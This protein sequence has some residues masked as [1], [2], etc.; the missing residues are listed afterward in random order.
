MARSKIELPV[1][2]SGSRVLNQNDRKE[3]KKS[4]F[5]HKKAAFI[6]ALSPEDTAVYEAVKEWR[7]R[8]AESENVPPYV[9]FGDKTIEELV[10]KKPRT[11]RELLTVFGIGAVKAERFGAALIRLLDHSAAD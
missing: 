9:I 6:R 2:L 7:R 3:A 5:Q 1:E 8:T 11:E 10:Q 4:V